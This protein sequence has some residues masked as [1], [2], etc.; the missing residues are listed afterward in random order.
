MRYFTAWLLCMTVSGCSFLLPSAQSPKLDG[1]CA[2]HPNKDTSLAATGE[3][4]GATADTTSAHREF[5]PQAIYLAE[6]IHV[7]P[8][9]DELALG[10]KCSLDSTPG[11]AKES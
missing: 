1:R 6:V 10:W 3:L 5:S 11:Q 9:L 7:L 8:L 2:S 4:R